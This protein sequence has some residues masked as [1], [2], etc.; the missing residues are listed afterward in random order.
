MARCRSALPARGRKS[1]EGAARG[2]VEAQV[3]AALAGSRRP[4]P[5]PRT[6]QV[7]SPRRRSSR[8]ISSSDRP[9][10]TPRP[11][12]PRSERRTRPLP[13][14]SPHAAMDFRSKA[15]S[16]RSLPVSAPKPAM[17]RRLGLISSRSVM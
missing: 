5:A 1:A 14:A 10:S 2:P 13:V 11:A 6:V 12:P 15:M 4:S 16:S 9:L 8:P 7:G 3:E 17:D